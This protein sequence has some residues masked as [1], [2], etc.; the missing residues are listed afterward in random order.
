M[1]VMGHNSGNGM[2]R[3]GET[4]LGIVE[5]KIHIR[6]H[7]KGMIGD[8]S[9]YAPPDVLLAAF[10]SRNITLQPQAMKRLAIEISSFTPGESA[11]IVLNTNPF[12]D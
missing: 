2:L 6:K 8:G 9:L 3:D 5:F 12:E 7:P 11:R 4:E 1:L 10:Q